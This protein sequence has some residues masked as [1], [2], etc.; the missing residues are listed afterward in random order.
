MLHSAKDAHGVEIDASDGKVG[1]ID[2]LYFDDAKWTIRY[3][4]VDTGG[5]LT[6]RKLL[7]TPPSVGAADWPRRQLSVRLSR[8]Q[9][10][11]SPPIDTAKPVSRQ[12][13]SDLYR[14]YGYPEYWNGPYLWGYTMLPAL[15]EQEPMELPDRREVRE[16]MEQQGNDSHLR[17]CRAV[18][19]YHIHTADGDSVG[20]VE[21][22]LFDERDWTIQLMLVDTRNWWPGR[23]VLVSPQRI[24]RVDWAARQVFVKVTR[25]ELEASPEYDSLKP[26]GQGGPHD[27]YRTP[28]R[29]LNPP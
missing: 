18:R 27:L 2:D 19:G 20:H 7:L 24:E 3:L 9:I 10:E 25:A 1:S 12:H 11:D 6:G 5:W 13:E 8:Q 17:S 22:F 15:L 16:Q 23:H 28:G 21:D 29:P 26:P 4:V 14:H